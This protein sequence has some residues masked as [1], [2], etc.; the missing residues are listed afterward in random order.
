M[1]IKIKWEKKCFTKQKTGRDKAQIMQD[2]R[3]T[4]Y[5]N[6]IMHTA[7]SS[8]CSKKTKV[9]SILN[10]CKRAAKFI[11][12]LMEALQVFLWEIGN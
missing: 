12:K 6:N 5:I 7:I 8:Y 11:D 9:R 2:F 3:I 4:P 10:L 1:H